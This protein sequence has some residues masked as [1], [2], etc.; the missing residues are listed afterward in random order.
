MAYLEIE[1]GFENYTFNSVNGRG[2]FCTKCTRTTQLSASETLDLI[3]EVV[4][5]PTSIINCLE[6]PVSAYGSE[7]IDEDSEVFILKTQRDSS[8]PTERAW[9]VETNE[10]ITIEN[11]SSPYGISTQNLFFQPARNLVRNAE[12]FMPALRLQESGYLRFQTTDKLS[13]LE[14]T[15]TVDGEDYTIKES[16]DIRIGG[17]DSILPAARMKPIKHMVDTL[18]TYKDMNLILATDTNGIPNR[19]KYI[20]LSD[21]LSIWLYGDGIQM[22]IGEDKA[23]ITGI[24]RITT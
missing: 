16:D 15:S 11:N 7:D 13:G 14:T 21:T 18:F 10:I 20:K 23:S 5:A 9:K 19:Y 3:S 17:T 6:K 12:L 22:K 24:E 1:Y 8:A 2:E 4:A